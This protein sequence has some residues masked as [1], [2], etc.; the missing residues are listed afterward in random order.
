MSGV[1]WDVPPDGNQTP[2][3]CFLQSGVFSSSCLPYG[4]DTD[5]LAGSE[6]KTTTCLFANGGWG[7]R[8]LSCASAAREVGRRPDRRLSHRN[9]RG[10]RTGRL[11]ANL[12]RNQ[13]VPESGEVSLEVQTP[14]MT[15]RRTGL[16]R[17]RALKYNLVQK[18]GRVRDGTPNPQ[19]LS[20]RIREPIQLVPR[21][22]DGEWEAM[23]RS[24]KLVRT[25]VIQLDMEIKTLTVHYALPIASC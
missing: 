17:L 7:N 13:A 4:P 8:K 6:W 10:G 14:Q 1:Y 12:D 23:K 18:M 16:E 15:N 5:R 9:A 24:R 22:V 11:E 21:G 3:P 2:D 19:E 25:F 20:G